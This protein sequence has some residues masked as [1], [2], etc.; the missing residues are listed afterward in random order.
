MTLFLILIIAA[1]IFG[2][3][4]LFVEAAAWALVVA[5]AL[6]VAGA[7]SAVLARRGTD[8]QIVV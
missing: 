7:V 5:L 8:R 4:G 3:I 6:L 2:G 1:L